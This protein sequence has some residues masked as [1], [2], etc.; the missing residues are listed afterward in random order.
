MVQEGTGVDKLPIEAVGWILYVLSKDPGSARE[1]SA[2]RAFLANR[3]TEEAGTAHFVTGFN[4][5]SGWMVLA[6]DRCADGILLEALIRAQIKRMAHGQVGPSVG[7][8]DRDRPSYLPTTTGIK[9]RLGKGWPEL[10][11]E[12]G[13]LP[14]SGRLP[15]SGRAMPRIS[16]PKTA[17]ATQ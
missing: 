9:Q 10:V 8:W 2:I 3:V 11:Q 16:G 14:A 4:E 15:T 17:C 13:L 6:S 7:R 1:V 5:E 12:C